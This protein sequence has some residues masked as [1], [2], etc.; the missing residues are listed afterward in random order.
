MNMKAQISP[1][2]T[3]LIT[4]VIISLVG[5]AYF[6]G[7][8]LIEKQSTATDYSIAKSFMENLDSVITEI[9]NSGGS[10]EMDIPL[11]VLRLKEGGIEIDNKTNTIIMEFV[12]KQPIITADSVVYLG[13]TTFADANSEV[14][15]FGKSSSSVLSLTS[16]TSDIGSIVKIKLHYRELDTQ[17]MSKG[18]KI[19]LV[20]DGPRDSGDEKISVSFDKVE[21]IENGAANGGELIVTY[22]KVK[23][24]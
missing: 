24:S 20:Q 22:V 11:G 10:E 18:Y 9:A 7:M 12:T 4:G 15:V 16:E 3:V 1:I 13:S 5:I 6:W 23:L 17:D 8:P 21:S 19:V 14:G 2:S